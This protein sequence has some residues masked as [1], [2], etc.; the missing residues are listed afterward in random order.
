MKDIQ[1]KVKYYTPF[2]II[3]FAARTCT[4][5]R[6]KAPDAQDARLVQML[7]DKGHHSVLEH[8]VFTFELS[9]F[10]RAVLQELARHRI[11]SYSVKSTRYTLNRLKD[12][13]GFRTTADVPRAI[14]YLVFQNQEEPTLVDISSMFSLH[15]TKALIDAGYKPDEVKPTLPE[16][17]RTEAV[18]TINLRSLM[19]L[20]HLRTTPQAFKE[21]RVLAYRMYEALP[22]EYKPL[23]DQV[24]SDIVEEEANS[25]R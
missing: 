1:A 18:V 4:D 12:E 23:C 19:N 9:G 3:G 22:D 16:G 14:K 2:E 11:A 17:F 24:V 8:A 6:E 10:S 7:V 13:P 20:L 25:V 5:T 21:F 15:R